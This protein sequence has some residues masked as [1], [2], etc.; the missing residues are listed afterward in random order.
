MHRGYIKLHRKSFDS[1]LMQNPNLWTFFCYCLL[2]ASHKDRKELINGSM[3]EIKAGQFIFGRKQASTDLRMSEQ[4]I[5]TCLKKLEKYEILISQSTNRFS[6]VT[7]IN[8]G[9]YQSDDEQL[10]SQLTNNQPAT[11]QQLTSNQPT[12]NH[13]QECNNVRIKECKNDITTAKFV[14]EIFYNIC[15]ERMSLS[16]SPKLSMDR[17]LKIQRLLN[18]DEY[19][20]RMF[21]ISY[22][23]V[24]ASSDFLCGKIGNFKAKFDWLIDESNMTKVLEGNYQN[25]T[26]Q[27]KNKKQATLDFLDEEIA[28]CEQQEQQTGEI[29][30]I[31]GEIIPF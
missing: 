7:L 2:K 31:Q 17:N 30:E 11:N 6:L 4:T 3:V 14:C 10:T 25:K 16:L 5:R 1:G 15:K 19:K 18:K 23:N 27:F 22:F 20:Q 21:W 29:I 24:V 8:W 26:S 9:L 13:R 28:R 12:T